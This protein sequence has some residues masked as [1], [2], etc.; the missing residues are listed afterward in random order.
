[1]ADRFL[2]EIQKK[3]MKELWDNKAD[4]ETEEI[5]NPMNCA[6]AS[7]KALAKYWSTPEE[8]KAWKDL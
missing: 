2:C 7:E 8:D 4:N 3:K 1:M 5:M 6:L